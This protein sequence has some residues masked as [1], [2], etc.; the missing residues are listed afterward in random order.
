[1][2][3]VRKKIGNIPINTIKQDLQSTVD[4]SVTKMQQDVTDF[5]D[6][7]TAQYPEIGGAF[8]FQEDP[9]GRTEITAD[10]EGKIISYRDSD[11]VKHENAGIKTNHLELT[12][13]GMTDFQKALKDS[14]FN[15]GGAGDYTDASHLEIPTPRLAFVN[16][17]NPKGETIFPQAKFVDYKYLMEFYDGA[18]NY[19]K[20]EVIFNA[21]GQSSMSKPK[22]NG[23]IDICNNNGWDDE[24]TFKL[25]IG[26][27]VVQDSYHLKAF[28]T[29]IFKVEPIVG[30]HLADLIVES[31]GIDV[32]RP[33]KKALLS[34][35]TFNSDS[36]T[37]DQID[38]ISLQMDNGA[39]CWPDGFPCIVFLDGEFYGVYMWS[40]KKHRD[41][42]HM[43]K[44]KTKHIHLDGTLNHTTIF[45]GTIDWTAF[46][47]RNPKNLCYQELHDGTYKYDADVVQDEIAGID[48][49]YEGGWVSGNY[50][51]IGKIVKSGNNY[52]INMV[53]DNA[54][55]PITSDASGNKNTA[56]SPD[57]KNK[58]KCGWVNCTTSVQVK[59]Y[60][61]DL[62]N[63]SAELDAI[64]TDKERKTFLDEYFDVE[65]IIDYILFAQITSN[66]DGWGK[67]WQW[68]TWD[69]KKWFMNYYDLDG[70][71][72]CNFVGYFAENAS[73]SHTMDYTM[74]SIINRFSPTEQVYRI[75]ADDIVTRY[76]QIR[77]EL[78]ISPEFVIKLIKDMAAQVGEDY[79]SKEYEK[80]TN[81]ECNRDLI[82]NEGWEMIPLAY[83]GT[84]PAYNPETVYEVGDECWL[85][86]RKFRA[87]QQRHGVQPYVQLGYHDS[88]WRLNKWLEERFSLLDT[89]YE[90][91][92]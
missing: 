68:T 38:D 85:S 35:Y 2:T 75:Y 7:E 14:G 53:D 30:Y 50:Y 33:W 52:F 44:K 59:Q 72:G 58:T 29:N 37:S 64:S 80:W 17:K 67:N 21:Q 5:I 48:K 62:S 49:N 56:D 28:Y 34:G 25:K 6:E 90:Y 1:M 69:G 71:F 4:T 61:I 24:D 73:R 45:G 11:G 22:K 89:K 57:F 20:K 42:Y 18:G 88:I 78:G 60:I 26:D 51:A 39:R 3:K 12:N 83:F 63:R 23:A 81:S 13:Q 19:F 74:E 79:Y 84:T 40:L 41:N 43:S 10:S 91:N 76:H 27:W 8:K 82:L 9:E 86:Y 54:A 66:Y 46:E 70:L 31:R 87:T 92:I 32:D 47:V 55:T 36:D 77:S 65:N 16:F 15:P